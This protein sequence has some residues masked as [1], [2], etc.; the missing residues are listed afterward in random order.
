LPL[1]SPYPIAGIFTALATSATYA[2]EAGVAHI[3]MGA[4]GKIE[5]KKNIELLGK[6]IIQ[7]YGE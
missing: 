3:M 6:E 1:Y 7:S 4:P 5:G 2:A